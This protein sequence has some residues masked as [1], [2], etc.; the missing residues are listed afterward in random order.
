MIIWPLVSMAIFHGYV[1]LPKRH[2][3]SSEHQPASKRGRVLLGEQSTNGYHRDFNGKL[4]H[5]KA[6]D[7][8]AAVGSYRGSGCKWWFGVVI[9]HDIP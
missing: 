9:T 1:R 6:G 4:T 7:F 5:N 8:P 2:T 3:C